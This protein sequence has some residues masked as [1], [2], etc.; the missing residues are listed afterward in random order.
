[1]N[2]DLLAQLNDI[3]T[4][5]PIGAWP[6]AWGWWALI[7]VIVVLL[8]ISVQLFRKRIQLLKAKKQAL[9]LL[10]QAD[11]LPALQKVSAVSQI[12]K[13]AALAYLPRTEVA[14]LNGDT[15][16]KWLNQH[17]DK[18]QISPELLTLSYQNSC[19]IEQA[20]LY[21]SQALQWLKKVLPLS[22]KKMQIFRDKDL[23]VDKRN[24]SKNTGVEQNV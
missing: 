15:W 22:E 19:T 20:N 13:R 12:L 16:A 10:K 23:D 14:Q 5:E 21:Y 17:N 3:Q 4:P 11:D 2:Q 18:V 6:L 24:R 7:I 8:F 1:M 9:K